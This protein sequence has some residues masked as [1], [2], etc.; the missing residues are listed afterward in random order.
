MS[1]TGPGEERKV[2]LFQRY[3]SVLIWT[4]IFVLIAWLQWPMLKGTF[5]RVAGVEAPPDGIAWQSDFQAALVIGREKGKL[6]LVDFS[7][8]WCPPCQVM[9]HDVWPDARVRAAIEAGY[10]PVLIN[11]DLASSQ[12]VAQRY[13]VQSIPTIVIVD[14]DGQVVRR[15][16]SMSVEKLLTFLQSPA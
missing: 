4:A 3:R 12:A 14:G 1:E 5:Y 11:I 8:D 13:E 16:G 9:K 15:G 6:L 2:G 7:A 10:V